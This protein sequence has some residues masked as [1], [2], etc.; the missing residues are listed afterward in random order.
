[1]ESKRSVELKTITDMEKQKIKEQDIL[2]RES[3]KENPYTLPQGYFAMVEDSVQKRIHSENHTGSENRLIAMLKPSLML[4]VTF[5]MIFG[6]GYGAMYL[7]G[8]AS[9]DEENNLI[10]MDNGSGQTEETFQTEEDTIFGTVRSIALL[11]SLTEDY[12]EENPVEVVNHQVNK[13]NIEQYLIESNIS[14][15]TLASLE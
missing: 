10:V 14:L 8:T 2:Q 13:D 4:A 15:I 3:L 7:T 1:M 6:L 9:Q 5:A 12:S 11:E